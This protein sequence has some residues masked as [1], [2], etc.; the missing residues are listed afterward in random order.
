MLD[1]VNPEITYSGPTYIAIR[2]G[3]HDSSTA[4]THG[5][6]YDQLMGL[7]EFNKVVK[8]ETV[9]KPVG[10]FFVMEVQMKS[11]DFQ[12]DWTLPYSILINTICCATGLNACTRSVCL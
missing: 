2:S 5:R 6:D 8:H 11:Q 1:Q 10:M 9:V 7:K 4:Y 12:K 3:K